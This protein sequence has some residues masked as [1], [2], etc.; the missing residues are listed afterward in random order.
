[1]A[2]EG[3]EYTWHARGQKW[4]VRFHEADPNAPSGSNSAS[5]WIVRIFRGKHSMD[6]TGTFHPPGIFKASSPFYSPK[7]ANDVHIPIRHPFAWPTV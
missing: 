1:M 2:L 7:L 5:G 3:R 6:E 4:T